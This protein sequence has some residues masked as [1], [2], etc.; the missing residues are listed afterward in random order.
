MLWSSRKAALKQYFTELIR[1]L[2]LKPFLSYW[3]WEKELKMRQWKTN[4]RQLM[5]CRSTSTCPLSQNASVSGRFSFWNTF[6]LSLTPLVLFDNI[7]FSHVTQ[8]WNEVITFIML[9]SNM[10]KLVNANWIVGACTLRRDLSPPAIIA[11]ILVG[12]EC[13]GVVISFWVAKMLQKE[14]SERDRE[15]ADAEPR[16]R[17]WQHQLS[18]GRKLPEWA[19][20]VTG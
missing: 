1:S 20:L 17:R 6:F 2:E 14:I 5:S 13:W 9:V 3:S 19:S 15:K 7:L 11:A 10:F 8:H 4:F 18:T 16:R 12:E